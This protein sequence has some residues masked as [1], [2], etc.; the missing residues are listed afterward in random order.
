[1]IKEREKRWEECKMST[2]VF[3]ALSLT[4]P[5]LCSFIMYSCLCLL[6]TMCDIGMYVCGSKL[7]SLPLCVPC[8]HVEVQVFGD[9]HGN[10]VHLFERDCS[11]QRRHQ[12]IIE[13]APA[14]GIDVCV[15]TV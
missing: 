6:N 5:A 4:P 11:V 13:E 12:K 10:T 7:S 3:Y 15:Y 8:R 14:V 1:M 9:K 2:H